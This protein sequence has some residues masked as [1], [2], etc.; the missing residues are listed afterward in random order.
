MSLATR[1]PPAT[2][3]EPPSQKSFC[4]ST[5]ISARVIGRGYRRPAGRGTGP[6]PRGPGRPR[7]PPAT[8][9]NAEESPGPPLPAVDFSAFSSQKPAHLTREA[10]TTLID[11]WPLHR[12]REV[13]APVRPPLG[14]LGPWRSF[15]SAVGRARV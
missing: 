6:S 7:G 11:T 15:T 12:P 14:T 1:A 10:S 3:S 9:E 2:G 5:T 4:R 13:R 8:R